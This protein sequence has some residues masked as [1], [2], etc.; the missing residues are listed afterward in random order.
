[1]ADVT[2]D[3]GGAAIVPAVAPG[4]YVITETRAP[5]G[6]IIT[7]PARTVEVKSVTPTVVTFTNRSENNLQI[8]KLDFYTRN[9]LSGATFKVGAN[10]NIV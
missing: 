3:A 6:Y 8:T 4:W 7:E 2:T 10:S 9:P 5:S 1:M